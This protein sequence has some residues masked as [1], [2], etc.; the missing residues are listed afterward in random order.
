MKICVML[1][2]KLFIVLVFILFPILN[3]SQNKDLKNFIE[4]KGGIF[5]NKEPLKFVEI[6]IYQKNKKIKVFQNQEDG[7]FHF[8]LKIDKIYILEFSK[9]EFCKIKIEFNTKVPR[10]NEIWPF[11]FELDLFEKD[12]KNSAFFEKNFLKKI[13]IDDNE[14]YFEEDLKYSKK[15]KLKKFIENENNKKNYKKKIEKG[16]IFFQKKLYKKAKIKFQE[17]NIIFNKKKYP[18]E[19]LEKIDKI[20]KK[21]DKKYK[22][23]FLKGE[24]F[25]EKKEYNSAIKFYKKSLEFKANSDSSKNRILE[26]KKII[27]DEKNFKNFAEI[28]KKFFSERKYEKAK[29][30]FLNALE[31]KKDIDLKIELDKVN[32]KIYKKNIKKGNKYIKNENF[33]KAI[34]EF[35]N[36]KKLFP[37]KKLPKEKLLEIK[38]LN[39][40]KHLEF[41]EIQKRKERGKKI[42]NNDGID[43]EIYLKELAKTAPKGVSEKI[44]TDEKKTLKIIIVNFDGI[45]NE[46]KEVKH[47]W[48]GLYYFKNGQNISKTYFETEVKIK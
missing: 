17:A 25:F 18:S 30:N 31:I 6:S 27:I 11:Y 45:A 10:K 3:F 36:A 26:I 24:Y 20:L 4:L 43:Y 41:L 35:E 1:K 19:M 23:N 7:S 34:L 42:L 12:E 2:K 39:K 16:N 8:D 32:E 33:N 5:F 14:R 48:G 15:I 21:N 40:K 44:I 46:Y 29:I 28:G 9:K 47:N 13:K 38:N 37:K 22:K